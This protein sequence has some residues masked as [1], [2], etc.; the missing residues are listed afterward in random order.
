MNGALLMYVLFCRKKE[1]PKTPV[2]TPRKAQ[3]KTPVKTPSKTPKKTIPASPAKTSLQDA[4]KPEVGTP[5]EANTNIMKGMF[6][7]ARTGKKNFPAV[8][9]E[10]ISLLEQVLCAV[11][12]AF[13]FQMRNK[14][15]VLTVSVTI[16]WT[17]FSDRRCRWND[18]FH[19][20]LLSLAKEV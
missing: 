11:D 16:C 7:L 18:I 6:I 20:D 17:T 2:K 19:C 4:A 3:T 5:V 10:V 8:I 14:Y 13:L 1:K 15:I 12:N 9:D